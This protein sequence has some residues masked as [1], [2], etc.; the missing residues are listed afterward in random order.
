[1][2]FCLVVIM[3][4]LV[5]MQNIICMVMG[6]KIGLA[7]SKGETVELPSPVKA[8]KEHKA[9]KEAKIENDRISTILQNIE[10]YDGT[11]FNQED[12]PWG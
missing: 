9:S 11:D 6:V 10:N 2:E 1:M 4:L 5:G 12:V 8:Y 3:L 7:L